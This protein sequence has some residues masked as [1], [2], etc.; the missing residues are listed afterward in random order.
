MIK[1]TTLAFALAAG[2]LLTGVIAAE[3]A[4]LS[5]HLLFARG[6]RIEVPA[7]VR[8]AGCKAGDV[9][10]RTAVER[11]RQGGEVSRN[12][13]AKTRGERTD[14]YLFE[15]A[16]PRKVLVRGVTPAPCAADP[17]RRREPRLLSSLVEA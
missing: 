7:E 1:K 3:F 9:Q 6:G 14:G 17:E 13:D 12:C 15:F 10:A 5:G 4:I 2:A 8:D 16:A 11:G